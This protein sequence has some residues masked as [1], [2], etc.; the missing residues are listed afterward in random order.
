[1]K[2]DTFF[3][4]LK[5]I[6]KPSFWLR[7]RPYSKEW[8]ETLS[9]LIDEGHYFEN[10]S[11]FTAT[12]AGVEVWI[13]NYPYASFDPL[14]KDNKGKRIYGPLPSR[15]TAERAYERLF[16]SVVKKAMLEYEYSRRPA[17]E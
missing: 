12:I 3:R 10:I 13:A 7:S 4:R 16:A 8:D 1:M 2:I 17:N 6:F 5:F 15:L 9:R 11:E 14:S